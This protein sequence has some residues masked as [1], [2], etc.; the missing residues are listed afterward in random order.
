MSDELNI[1][2]SWSESKLKEISKVEYGKG[3]TKG[4]RVEGK[5]PVVASSGIV[6]SHKEAIFKGPLVTTGRK[7][8][9]GTPYYI[10]SDC[11]VIDTAYAISMS[12]TFSNKFFYW[13]LNS[14]DMA[15]FQSSTA[16]PSLSRDALYL[17]DIPIPAQK[18]QDRIVSKIE[19]LFSKIEKTEKAL[20]EA[21]ALL[22]KYRESLLAKA[23][24]GELIPQNSKD[25]P[26]SELL[27]RIRKEQAKS[28]N[29]KKKK[30][31]LPPISKDEVPF[32]IPGSWEWVRLGDIFKFIDYR[33]KNPPRSISG[34]RI[35]TAKNIRNGFIKNKP[36]E[37][38]SEETYKN[39]MVRGFPRTGDILFITE[40]HTMGYVAKVDLEYKFALA[41]RTI[42]LQPLLRGYESVIYH[43]LMSPYF[44]LDIQRKSTGAAAKGIK[45][46]ILKNMIVPLP[47]LEECKRLSD[48]LD[49]KIKNIDN[50]STGS[51]KKYNLLKR[52]KESI[53]SNAFQGKLVPQIPE[54]G[55]GHELLAE[56][57]KA[58]ELEKPKK[59]V[60]K[61]KAAKKKTTKGKK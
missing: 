33:G 29:G 24:R 3:L 34:V 12:G 6:G 52:L 36:I 40:G 48:C 50:I 42:T 38:I 15:K 47:P 10:D 19:S 27:K 57:L 21:E 1:P 30:K 9:L 2:E 23:F 58:K 4:N 18:E 61:K 43:L 11:W 59:K 7:G 32:D 8:S 39:W 56:I 28:D 49:F 37:Y 22:L 53:L 20:K 55:T 14:K 45:A 16:I 13:Y 5:Y 46:S 17:L 51:L 26:A 54:E 44:Q 35:I 31:E 60:A 25:E 41:Q